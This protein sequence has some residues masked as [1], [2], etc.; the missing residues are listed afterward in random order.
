LE[1]LSLKLLLTYGLYA[2]LTGFQYGQVRF[3]LYAKTTQRKTKLFIKSFAFVGIAF[4]YIFIIYLGFSQ[5]WYL[6]FLLFG[7]GL[8]TEKFYAE[9]EKII[10]LHK[11]GYHIYLTSFFAIP[12][13]GY[14]MILV[15]P[16]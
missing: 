10:G 6:P 9:F 14:L 2:I 12:V 11:F 16:S 7:F 15:M 4:Q 13:C 5:Q 8:L 3:N 1:S